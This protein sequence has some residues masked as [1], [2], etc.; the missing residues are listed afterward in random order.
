[1]PRTGRPATAPRRAGIDPAVADVTPSPLVHIRRR[2]HVE[3]VHR[4]HVAVVDGSGRL[5]AH[6]GEPNLLV[7]PRSSFKPFQALPVVE[8][9]A[10]ARSELRAE[11]LA[12]IA[13]SHGGTDAHAALAAEILAK[14]G[15]GV[16]DLACGTHPPFDKPTAEALRAR[17][18]SPTP[19]RHNCSGKHA[20][21][22]LLARFLGAPISGYT[23][24]E[25][26]VQQGIWATF[27]EVVGEAF[28]DD[29]PA[30][31]GCSAPNPRMPLATLAFAF[32][33]L[34]RGADASGNPRPALVAIRDAM[35]SHP[36]FVAGEGL[37]DTVLMRALPGVV[38]KI[39][40]EAVHAVALP[41]QG[42]GVAIKV[43][44]GSD[45]ALGPATIAVLAEL[46]LI[47]SAEREKLG[48]FAGRTLRNQA[49][50]E[51]GDIRG[52]ARL[53]REPA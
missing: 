33:L 46:G 6:A 24:P 31:D 45:R 42:W 27:E 39:G 47:G 50:L 10:F 40:A 4:G 19:L 23:Q 22:L 36:E 11:A 2:G 3:S 14:A 28:S 17:G 25:H 29:G 38:T 15:A 8:S 16:D 20:G 26:P 44:D 37:L 35:R 48:A 53:V 30:I 5:I 51:V 41:G 1:M 34:G 9:G 12:L 13:G 32:A 43:E 49:G 52:V 18:E 7:Y 21:M